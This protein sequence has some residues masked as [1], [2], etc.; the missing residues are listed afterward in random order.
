M[1]H[2]DLFLHIVVSCVVIWVIV[3][4][5][6]SLWLIVTNWSLLCLIADHWSLFWLTVVYCS[7]LRSILDYFGP[8][9]VI[10][11]LCGSFGLCWTVLWATM[12][13]SAMTH[14]D[15]QCLTI[16]TLW[17]TMTQ[18]W[19]NFYFPKFC[20]KNLFC[21]KWNSTQSGIQ[22]GCF[23]LQQLFSAYLFPKTSTSF[24]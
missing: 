7:A 11:A 15:S 19:V 18:N 5:F 8:L 17:H 24:V 16:F 23:W 13:R 1:T 9:F 22:G 2:C 20:S 10:L 21:L 12:S 3:V 14:N 4:H 6:G